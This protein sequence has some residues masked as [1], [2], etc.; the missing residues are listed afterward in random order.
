MTSD[1]FRIRMMTAYILELDRRVRLY[2]AIIVVGA[3]YT[4]LSLLV[5]HC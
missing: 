3:L 4:V 1:E 5:H 2:R